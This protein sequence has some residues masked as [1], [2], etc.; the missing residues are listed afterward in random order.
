LAAAALLG[1]GEGL[2]HLEDGALVGGGEVFDLLE[3]LEQAGPP[4][5]ALL[6]DRFQ[7]EQLVALTP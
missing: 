4:G 3:P 6:G 2:D 1:V 5:R 7:T